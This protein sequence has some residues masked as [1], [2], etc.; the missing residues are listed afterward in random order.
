M[1]L[2]MLERGFL[3]C[4]VIDLNDSHFRRDRICAKIPEVGFDRC[5]IF[6]LQMM[7]NFGICIKTRQN[8]KQKLSTALR[9][10]H[11]V[12]ALHIYILSTHH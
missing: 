4:F 6:K 8:Q 3:T 1:C 2:A 9:N 7:K 11:R 10:A 12:E 5:C